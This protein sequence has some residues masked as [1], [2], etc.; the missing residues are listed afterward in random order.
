MNVYMIATRP[1]ELRFGVLNRRLSSCLP[2]T[3]SGFG[4]LDG[5]TS[6]LLFGSSRYTGR[7]WSS[8]RCLLI[9]GFPVW[10]AS[11]H[12]AFRNDVDLIRAVPV[13]GVPGFSA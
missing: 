6:V 2:S 3:F 12:G 8:D 11:W 13:V 7:S 1:I 5:N 9:V 4:F 10:V